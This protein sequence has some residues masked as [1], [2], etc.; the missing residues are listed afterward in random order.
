MPKESPRV[1][2]SNTKAATALDPRPWIVASA[3]SSIA[4]SASVA[5]AQT[6]SATP[7]PASETRA[8]G[9]DTSQETEEQQIK[10][11]RG[12]VEDLKV[13][14]HRLQDQLSKSTQAQSSPAG[15]AIAAPP[16]PPP[17]PPPSA[18]PTVSQAP[19]P[20]A[21]AQAAP[22]APS[23]ATADLLH[24]VT[25]NAM[26][27]TYYEYNFN[28]P[29]GRANL[30]RAYDVSS[31]SFSLNQADIVLESAPE[32]AAGK[33]W[34][35]RLDLQFGQATATLQGNPANELRPAIYR[36]IFQ[37]YGTYI[38]PI[39]NGLSAD[40]G[41]WASSLGYENNYTKDELNYSRSFWFDFLPFY[42]TGLRAKYAV[43]DKVAVNF[44]IV[45]G[46]EQTEAF[47]N[48]KDI[49]VGVVATPTSKVTWTVNYY[50]G[51]EHPDVTYIQTPTPV[52]LALPNQQGTYF[53]PIP[54]PPTGKLNIFDTYLNWQATPSLTL[55]AEA[56]Y[57]EERLYTSSPSQADW[58]GALYAAY[59]LTPR[60]E[61]A[62]RAEYLSDQ[63]A[64]FTGVAQNL[65]EGTLTV[66]YRP[67]DGFSLYGEF[68]RDSATRP[69]F[70][71]STLNILERAQP[72]IGLG[73]V[74][75]FG[76]KQGPW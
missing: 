21:V 26:L 57:V 14:V 18:T 16:P 27:D 23:K 1:R 50:L 24:G 54:S 49:L 69:Y 43:N 46:T 28:N 71:S 75:W 51:Q 68:R 44:W 37:A 64:L 65:W 31:N 35:M 60:W 74:W 10:A 30:L 52:Q 39:G 59:Q 13:L 63:G 34:G 53:Q 25:I 38:L 15:E 62:A 47:N 55:A 20:T 67:A 56:D 8:T 9:V 66:N 40:F 22:S 45:N 3:A 6:P 12:E 41:K 33:R 72:T 36:N 29:I 61:L 42:H 73:A 5:A 2:L 17:P 19:A 7:Q 48:F 70:L 58:G 11:L 76:Q 32:V 4:L